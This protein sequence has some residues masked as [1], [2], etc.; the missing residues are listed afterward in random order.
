MH[1]VAIMRLG[2]SLD[3]EAKALASDL[4]TT[5]YEAR[6]KLKIG[7][8]AI[9]LSTPDEQRAATLVATLR[10]RGHDVLSC[11][12]ADVV[13]TAEMLSL[14]RFQ[15]EPDALVSNE[16]PI[17]RLR[18]SD[19]A[20]LISATHRTR[21]ETSNVVERAGIPLSHAIFAGGRVAAKRMKQAAV[22]HDE[23]LESVLYIYSRTGGSPWSLRE[24]YARFLTLYPDVSPSAGRNF[25]LAV[26]RIRTQARQAAFDDRLVA[27]KGTSDESDLL[28]YLLATSL[29]S[30]GSPFR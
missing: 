24:T 30:G 22:S 3:D 23:H 25:A 27:R 9:V 28:A 29:A 17:T 11:R 15:I 19:I 4:E 2:T 6:L 21:L 10:A 7:L 16:P 18:W 12:I 20:V 1:A 14:R 13:T 5:V 26:E 8:P